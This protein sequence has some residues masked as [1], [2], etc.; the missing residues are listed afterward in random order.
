MKFGQFESELTASQNLKVREIVNEIINF[1][2]NDDM[3]VML[4]YLLGMNVENN[5]LMQ[6]ITT[7][8]RNLN[9]KSFIIDRAETE[10]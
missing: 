7:F 3:I 6:Q 8:A 5:D 2:V 4:I 10:E 9:T 1:G